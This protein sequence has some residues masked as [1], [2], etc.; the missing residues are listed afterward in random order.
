MIIL[1]LSYPI[2]WL[3]RHVCSDKAEFPFWKGKPL[4]G[5]LLTV[6]QTDVWSVRCIRCHKSFCRNMFYKL[7]SFVAFFKFLSHK[8]VDDLKWF[9]KGYFTVHGNCRSLFDAPSGGVTWLDHRLKLP[10]FRQAE[11]VMKS[12]FKVSRL[13]FY[14]CFIRTDHYQTRQ[15]KHN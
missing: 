11:T 14:L 13:S 6:Y 9:V 4:F 8:N 3:V 12:F 1:E 2:V 7:K 5:A 10:S 15:T